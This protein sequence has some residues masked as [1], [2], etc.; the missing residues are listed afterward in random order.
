[1]IPLVDIVRQDKKIKPQILQS[2][3]KVIDKGDFILGSDVDLFEKEFAS[4]VGTK[5]VVGVSSGSDA[6]TL[7]L[8]ALD[9]KPGDEVIVQANT[10][11]STV[12]PIIYI[13]AKPILVDIDPKTY[14]IDT[15]QIEKK[16]TKKTKAILPV[17]LY[18]QISDMTK[19]LEI[20]K[21][22]K[23]F[24]IEDACQA[25]GSLFYNKKAGA[26]GDISC[27]SFYPGKNLG[28]YGD[29]GAVVTNNKQLVDKIKILRNIGQVRKYEHVLKGVNNRLDTVQAAVLRIKLKKLDAWNKERRKIAKFFT[30]N[31]EGIVLATPTEIA[32]SKSNFHLYVVRV[33][34]RDKLL[35]FLHKN[36]IFAGIHYPTPIHLHKAL[37]D[38][39]YKKGSFPIA[40]KYANEIISLPIFPY[41]KR[42]EMDKIVQV[43]KKFYETK[44]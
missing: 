40:E 10:F 39:G 8:M 12:L 24:V 37:L 3:K 38:L 20:A 44:K 19:I 32:E 33:K 5:Y 43:V 9:I 41:M 26:F 18:G 36:E 23:L 35:K 6:I 15:S 27:F 30:K 14:N 13:G 1:M 29:G 22:H 42:K 25:H 4:F 31:L 16:I 2:V 11:I 21:K 34:N 28:A 17:H 7:A